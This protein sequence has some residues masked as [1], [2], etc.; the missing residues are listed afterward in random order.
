MSDKEKR[1]PCFKDVRNLDSATE[2]V[3]DVVGSRFTPEQTSVELLSEFLLALSGQKSVVRRGSK[4]KEIFSGLFVDLSDYEDIEDFK[5]TVKFHLILKLFAFYE[6]TLD[7]D[8]H[9]SHREGI[10]E[11]RQKLISAIDSGSIEERSDYLNTLEALLAGFQSAGANRNWCA[12]SFLPISRDFLAGES[13]WKVTKADRNKIEGCS[14]REK[15]VLD[16]FE[17][18]SRAFYCRGGDVLYLQLAYALS[19][20]AEKLRGIHETSLFA[21]L[22]VDDNE[23]DP[24]YLKKKISVGL[25]AILDTKRI[26]GLSELVDVIEGAY[27]WNSSVDISKTTEIELGI[28]WISDNEAM[29]ALGWMF[30]VELSRLL[31]TRMDVMD[32]IKMLELECSMQVLRTYEYT[33]SV[34]INPATKMLPSLITV[35]PFSDDSRYKTLS[36]YSFKEVVAMIEEALKFDE[37]SSTDGKKG[38]G[39]KAKEYRSPVFK[40]IAKSI[41]FVVPRFGGNEHF[42]LNKNLISLFVMTSMLPRE[43]ITL[44][45]FLKSIRLRHGVAVDSKSFSDFNSQLG[46]KQQVSDSQIYKWIVDML[47]ESGFFQPLSDSI[48]LVINNNEAREEER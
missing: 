18:T 34:K 2:Q 11:V 10:E 36:T 42:V 17:H 29:I 28:G 46:I 9:S 23:Y 7:S 16:C 45:D 32:S 26:P 37:S 14:L 40:K 1:I 21:D 27:T 31:S 15:E 35:S 24:G 44:D 5:Y 20:S 8:I 38:N 43:S 19:Q 30:A 39:V 48:S 3:W 41:Q 47:S 4:E 13:I 6:G 33:C 12:K 25:D 22:G